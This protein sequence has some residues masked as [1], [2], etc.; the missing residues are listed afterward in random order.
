[1]IMNLS[2]QTFPECHH[3]K[4]VTWKQFKRMDQGHVKVCTNSEAVRQVL[5]GDVPCFKPR[6]GH[7]TIEPFAPYSTYASNC[8]R[9]RPVSGVYAAPAA[10]CAFSYFL[11]MLHNLNFHACLIPT[12]LTLSPQATSN[13]RLFFRKALNQPPAQEEP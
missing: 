12:I 9:L 1:M 2:F 6:N 13:F 3:K 8:S 4:G 7:S 10:S 11:Q 5:T